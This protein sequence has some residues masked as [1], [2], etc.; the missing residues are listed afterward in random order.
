[1]SIL[2]RRVHDESSREHDVRLAWLRSDEP[3]NQMGE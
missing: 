1:M 3:V 2:T